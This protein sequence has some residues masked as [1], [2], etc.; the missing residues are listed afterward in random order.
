[1]EHFS[2]CEP[3]QIKNILGF[4]QVQFKTDMPAWISRPACEEP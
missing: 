4:T 3:L 2:Y 1:M